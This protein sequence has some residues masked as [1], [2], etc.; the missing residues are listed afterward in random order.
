MS[1][2]AV[3]DTSASLMWPQHY[4]IDIILL[5]MEVLLGFKGFFKPGNSKSIS[6]L[7]VLII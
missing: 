7:L 3:D 1:G 4:R 2:P 5:V 6:Q